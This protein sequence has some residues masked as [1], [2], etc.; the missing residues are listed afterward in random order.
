M[1][2]CCFLLVVL[3]ASCSRENK[4]DLLSSCWSSNFYYYHNEYC[5]LT[6]STGLNRDGMLGIGMGDS[7]RFYADSVYLGDEVPF[8]YKLTDTSLIINMANQYPREFVKSIDSG[9]VN[10]ISTFEYAYGR[11]IL[12]EGTIT[13]ANR[14]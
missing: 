6:D 7:T 10:F 3:L 5:F 14:H 9:K 13:P 11:E 1:K 8:T 12:Q 4:V 2:K